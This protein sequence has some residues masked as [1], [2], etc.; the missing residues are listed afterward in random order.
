MTVTEAP[1]GIFAHR[2]WGS[3]VVAPTIFTSATLSNHSVSPTARRHREQGKGR[4][5]SY[6]WLSPLGTDVCLAGRLHNRRGAREVQLSEV[7]VP[8][9]RIA[10]GTG[11]PGMKGDPVRPRAVGEHRSSPPGPSNFEP[12]AS[13][14]VVRGFGARA[15]RSGTGGHTDRVVG[16]V[17]VVPRVEEE[18]A[19]AGGRPGRGPRRRPPPRPGRGPA[20]GSG[21]APATNPVPDALSCSDQ[22]VA[23]PVPPLDFHTRYTLPLVSMNGDGVDGAAQGRLAL[24]RCRGRVDERPLGLGRRGHRDAL[25]ATARTGHLG[26]V[27]EVVGASDQGHAGRPG[28]I[29][30]GPDREG[31]GRAFPTA[32]QWI[33][34]VDSMIWIFPATELVA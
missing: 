12:L 30:G 29:G 4:G 16:A 18:V 5:E 33:R 25:L 14:G 13:R 6:P 27:V 26:R 28:G 34:S 20:T 32:L 15:E 17:P 21:L 3:A 22:I 9:V 31:C 11:G 19:P 7:Q 23:G 8:A 1:S 10:D 24:E 2:R